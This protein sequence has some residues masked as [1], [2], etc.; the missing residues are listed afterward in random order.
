MR[1]SVIEFMENIRAARLAVEHK[2]R[3]VR[4]LE[5]LKT[6]HAAYKYQHLEWTADANK[7]Y[8][9]VT[10]AG[11]LDC[12]MMPAI[13]AVLSESLIEDSEKVIFAKLKAILPAATSDWM[14]Q[15]QAEFK[16]MLC[17]ALGDSDAARAPQPLDLAIAF[18]RCTS[19]HDTCSRDSLQLRFP[20]ILNH[21]CLRT[22][23]CY[24][25][26]VNREGLEPYDL[27]LNDVATQVVGQSISDDKLYSWNNR[28]KVDKTMVRL[29]RRAVTACGLDPNTATF[30]EMNARP[31]R[32][33]C[34]ACSDSTNPDRRRIFDWHTAVRLCQ[35]AGGRG[36]YSSLRTRLSTTCVDTAGSSTT[37]TDAMCPTITGSVYPKSMQRGLELS[38][39]L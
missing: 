37:R 5:T 31:E 2:D 18:F 19:L 24:V 39:S 38:K 7:I 8:P 28:L 13:R 3:I 9:L 20:R 30:T 15:R 6:A 17:T 23:L 29:L 27:A 11:Y 25:L 4:R 14:Q 10:Y 22:H 34:R 33:W 36:L 1:G 32:L 35:H 16:D 21:P 26:P 12:A